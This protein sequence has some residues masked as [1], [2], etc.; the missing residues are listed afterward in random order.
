LGVSLK[1]LMQ[2]ENAWFRA[3]Y[4]EET[5]AARQI[6]WQFMVRVLLKVGVMQM[7][8]MK[9]A[10]GLPKDQKTGGAHIPLASPTCRT[11]AAL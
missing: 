4:A 2:G 3:W 11:L 9:P 7:C 5:R 10:H 8:G 6:V 1:R